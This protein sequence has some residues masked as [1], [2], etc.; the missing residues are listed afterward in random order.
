MLEGR[1]DAV[2]IKKFCSKLILKTWNYY[3]YGWR[4]RTQYPP[5]LD[6]ELEIYINWIPKNDTN[7]KGSVG[8]V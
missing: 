7:F 3:F 2:S 6:T 5:L 8:V 1:I 4:V